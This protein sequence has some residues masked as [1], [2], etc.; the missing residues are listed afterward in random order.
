MRFGVGSVLVLFCDRGHGKN[1]SPKAEWV[2]LCPPFPSGEQGAI[3]TPGNGDGAPG[4]TGARGYYLLRCECCVPKV[5]F[6]SVLDLHLS[7]LEEPAPSSWLGDL[8]SANVLAPKDHQ[9]RQ[10][11]FQAIT[12]N[13][14]GGW[15][16]SNSP[17]LG[18]KLMAI[19]GSLSV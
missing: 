4:E 19:F 2:S 18:N 12:K 13:I 1:L 3:W 14:R 5:T 11:V 6:I 17:K 16:G 9:G 15:E 8:P 10:F 7:F